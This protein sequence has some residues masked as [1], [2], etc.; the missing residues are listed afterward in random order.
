[1]TTKEHQFIQ[2]AHQIG[3][4]GIQ[5]SKAYENAQQTERLARIAKS[6]AVLAQY[7]SRN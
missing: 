4:V 7:Q 3:M 2:I 6:M 1:M 5:I